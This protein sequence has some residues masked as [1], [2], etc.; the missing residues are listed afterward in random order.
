MGG[1]ACL[2]GEHQERGRLLRIRWRQSCCIWRLQWDQRSHGRHQRQQDLLR[3]DWR[4]QRTLCRLD[5]FDELLR[6][7]WRSKHDH[8]RL[9]GPQAINALLRDS[10]CWR[11]D[12]TLIDLTRFGGPK[13]DHATEG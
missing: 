8:G 12:L 5:V 11:V 7:V 10:T 6:W 3:G 2:D 1:G 13:S 9:S 4:N